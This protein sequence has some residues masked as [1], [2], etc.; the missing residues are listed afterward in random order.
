AVGYTGSDTARFEADQ[1]EKVHRRSLY[2]FWKRT[3][4]PAAMTTL[5]AP[6]RE[7]CTARRGRTNTPL[8]A[9]LMMNEPQMMAA[10]LAL[11]EMVVGLDDDV[12]G[13]LEFLFG[14]VM[15]RMPEAVERRVLKSML[16]DLVDQYA[17]DLETA[18]QLTNQRDATLAAWTVV[19]STLINTDEV[20]CR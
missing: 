2:T 18:N 14:R 3:S 12:D 13:R 6:S 16:A 4:A 9:L 8:Q 7:S 20:M 1:G 5:D 15:L 19:A 17:S 10:S 11:A